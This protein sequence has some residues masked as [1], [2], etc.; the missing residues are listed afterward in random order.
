M[1]AKSKFQ[2]VKEYYDKGLWSI[3]RV[4][5]SVEKGWITAA[6]FEAITGK[7]YEEE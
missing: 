6:E 4:R 2:K 3:S 1:A 7:P 5:D